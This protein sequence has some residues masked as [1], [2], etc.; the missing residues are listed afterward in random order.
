MGRKGRP[1][2]STSPQGVAAHAL[3]SM[4]PPRSSGSTSRA[5]SA[6]SRTPTSSASAPSARTSRWPTTPSAATAG[7]STGE[8]GGRSYPLVVS[9]YHPPPSPLPS[10]RPSPPPLAL[11]PPFDPPRYG[12]I[13]TPLA[14][15]ER[16]LLKSLE[17]LGVRAMPRYSPVD[18]VE[19]VV[20]ASGGEGR[21][22]GL[23][24]SAMLPFTIRCARPPPVS[25]CRTPPAPCSGARACTRRTSGSCAR[26]PPT[27]WQRADARAQART[28]ACSPTARGSMRCQACPRH[29][30]KELLSSVKAS[31]RGPE[32]TLAC[33]SRKAALVPILEDLEG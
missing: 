21:G 32:G 8:E 2:H 22:G 5:R 27:S 6:T 29:S 19:G 20:Q 33:A 30:R 24:V 14:E 15:F 7:P 26:R 31:R 17:L 16:T 28:A 3:P 4:P 25:A 11:C 18:M 13:Y 1:L 10:T 12:A 9:S 23:A